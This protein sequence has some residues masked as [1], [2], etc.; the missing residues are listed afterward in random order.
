MV[1]FHSSVIEKLLRQEGAESFQRISMWLVWL[2]KQKEG[3]SSIL[4]DRKG[5]NALNSTYFFF[6]MTLCFKMF[7]SDLN[8]SWSNSKST[9]FMDIKWNGMIMTWVYKHREFH[10]N[11]LFV[12]ARSCKIFPKE[13]KKCSYTSTCVVNA[14]LQAWPRL[15]HSLFTSNWI[16]LHICP[17]SM[18]LFFF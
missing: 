1:A 6:D 15:V 13:S 18:F 2:S 8:L 10:E 4:T 3:E 5:L 16:F 14:S 9:V 17:M 7:Q 12:C 11:K